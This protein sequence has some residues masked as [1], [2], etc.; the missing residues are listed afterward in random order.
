MAIVQFGDENLD[1]IEA[2]MQFLKSSFPNLTSLQY[3]INLKKNETIFD[4]EV[5]LFQ[6]KNFITEQFED[7][8][9][10]IGPKSFFQTNPKQA[11]RLYQQVRELAN[12][13][14]NE[15]VY[16]LYCGTGTIGIF[17]S[18]HAK[19]IIGVESIREAV[20]DARVN[21]ELNNIENTEFIAG[22]LKDILN[23]EFTNQHGKPDL[24][25]CDPPRA[26]MHQKVVENIL[27]I[28]PEKIIYV[29]CNPA[30]QA[31][32]ISYLSS[33]Y[34]INILQPVDMFPHTQHVEN[35][36]LLTKRS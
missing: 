15:I 5:V 3:I 27:S 6:G 7:F 10:Q 34:E 33:L 26:G 21:S 2:C 19:Q 29:S 17:L 36:A 14:G 1:K 31:R 28:G 16:D 32:D 4:Q 11:L 12:L 8:T 9:F 22:D 25:V 20:D 35:I 30:T 13:S 18:Q 23:E 24:I